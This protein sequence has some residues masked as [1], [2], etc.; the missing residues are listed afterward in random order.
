MRAHKEDSLRCA[1]LGCG[2]PARKRPGSV[3][4]RSG[5]AGTEEKTNAEEG[6]IIECSG[7]GDG[8][9]RP[10]DDDPCQHAARSD[11]IAPP[12]GGNLEK[13]ICQGK[14]AE[15]KTHLDRVYSQIAHHRF[16]SKR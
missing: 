12:T 13:P 11:A 3:R 8:E 15:Y 10:P 2:K 14:S 9:A 7:S 4:P 5:L 6:N 1:A 16:R